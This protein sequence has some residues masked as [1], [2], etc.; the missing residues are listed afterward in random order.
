MDWIA[1][2]N[3]TARRF[4][5]A[6]LDRDRQRLLD[7]MEAEELIEPPAPRERNGMHWIGP[8]TVGRLGRPQSPQK[9]I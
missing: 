6:Q 8:H 7:Q 4:R 9:G 1:R 5:A 3:E 2:P